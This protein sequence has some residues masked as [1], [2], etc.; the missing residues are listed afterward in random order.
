MAVVMLDMLPS[1]S[2]ENC[3]RRSEEHRDGMRR[4]G[5]HDGNHASQV[6][7]RISGME[8][9]ASLIREIVSRHPQRRVRSS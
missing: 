8:T 1:V 6:R 7:N 4:Y 2:R 9:T 5:L 3:S